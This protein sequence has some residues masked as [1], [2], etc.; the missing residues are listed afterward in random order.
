MTSNVLIVTMI[1][2]FSREIRRD[3]LQM[4]L[5]SAFRRLVQGVLT[6]WNEVT[7]R[8]LYNH[9]LAFTCTCPFA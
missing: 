2:L 5:N 4:Q 3:R 7:C 1:L 9:L 6:V 8:V